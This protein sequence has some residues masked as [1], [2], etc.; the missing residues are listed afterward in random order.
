MFMIEAV[1]A[2]HGD[3][4]LLHWGAGK[5]A[6]IDGGPDTVYEN[7]RKPRLERLE[8]SAGRGNCNSISQW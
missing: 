7:F 4:L 2:K 8:T 3:C 1:K 6:L 5:L